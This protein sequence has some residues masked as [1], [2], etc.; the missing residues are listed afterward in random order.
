MTGLGHDKEDW[1]TAMT[2]IFR[3]RDGHLRASV[4]EFPQLLADFLETDVAENPERCDHLLAGLGQGRDGQPFEAYGNI[5]ELTAGPDGAEI[6]N[7][8]DD[9]LVPLRL[10]LEELEAALTAWRQAME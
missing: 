2:S 9:T 3:D 8:Y 10:S 6:R 7:A 4:H 1:D 5:Y